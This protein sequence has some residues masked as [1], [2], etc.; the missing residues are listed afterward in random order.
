MVMVNRQE[1]RTTNA[2]ELL[3]QLRDWRKYWNPTDFL[4]ALFLGLVLSALDSGTD[5]ALA[6]EYPEVCEVGVRNISTICGTILPKSVEAMTYTFC[7]M[8]GLLLGSSGL[9]YLFSFLAHRHLPSTCY[10][11]M[12]TGIAYFLYS[13][14]VVFCLLSLAHHALHNAHFNKQRQNFH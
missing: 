3:E 10:S 1:S 2:T 14:F 8:P 6:A 5:L 12:A 7:A 11:N 4:F 13:T 9:Q